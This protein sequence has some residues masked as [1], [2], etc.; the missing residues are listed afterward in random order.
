MMVD[1]KIEV[2]SVFKEFEAELNNTLDYWESHALDNNNAGF[3]GQINFKNEKNETA[4][5][6]LILNT[7][8]LWSFAAVSNHLQTTQYRASCNRAYHYLALFF[9]DKSDRGLYWELANNARP[10]SIQKN[11]V[12][13]A[14]A[15]LALCE[16]F[17]FSKKPEVKDWAL[18]LFEYIELFGFDAQHNCYIN[19]LNEKQTKDVEVS[20]VTKSLGTHLHVLEAY[21][22]MLKF[23]DND[24]IKEK[25]RLL[26]EVLLN[27]FINENKHCETAIDSNG[28]SLSE[29]MFFGYNVE[30][31]WMLVEAAEAISD[32]DLITRTKENLVHMVDVFLQEAIDENGAVRYSKCLESNTVDTDLHWWTQIEA[33]IAIRYAYDFTKNGDYLMSFHRIWDFIKEH[34][35][36]KEHGEW[37]ARLKMDTTRCE[38]DKIAMWKS[39]YHISRMCLKIMA[40]EYTNPAL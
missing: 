24:R 5:K 4:S 11:T 27:D 12:G 8:I 38:D 30:V 22:A 3:I 1:S 29:R 33:M 15:L 18:S 20:K 2:S 32:Q 28:N 36:D 23:Y 31:P 10:E 14:Y 39:P 35:M 6:G 9:K 26:I 25:I 34:F 21:T 16:Y 37:F 17:L 40:L 19:V 13:Q 7:R